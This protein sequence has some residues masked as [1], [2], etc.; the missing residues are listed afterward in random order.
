MT[1]LIDNQVVSCLA[2]MELLQEKI[3]A[4]NKEK[5]ERAAT[6]EKKIRNTE[7]NMAVLEKWLENKEQTEHD[8][9]SKKAIED[10]EE[11]RTQMQEEEELRQKKDPY[12]GNPV[13]RAQR[14][15]FDRE[16]EAQERITRNNIMSNYR[17]YHDRDKVDRPVQE[18]F[19]TSDHLH[20]K[21]AGHH[22]VPRPTDFMK[23]FI[24]ATYNLFQ[25]QQKRIDELEIKLQAQHHTP[26]Q[27]EYMAHKRAS[28]FKAHLAEKIHTGSP[29]K[30]QGCGG[31][32]AICLEDMTSGEMCYKLNT[33]GMEHVFH[34]ECG[35]QQI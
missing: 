22:H 25:I 16:K 11:L 27:L 6:K 31:S 29:D 9:M 19:H 7:P 26:R 3:K 28:R 33:G 2:E 32:C 34:R 17:K 15:T 21:H 30:Y 18:T 24:E 14:I 12:W 4:L 13:T 8:K 35:E 10:Y 20:N 23:N 1:A 5:Q